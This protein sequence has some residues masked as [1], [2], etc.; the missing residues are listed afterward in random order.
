MF[1]VI[2]RRAKRL[3]FAQSLILK[4]LREVLPESSVTFVDAPNS[5]SLPF[6]S[7]ADERG[8][9]RTIIHAQMSR[10]LQVGK[11]PGVAVTAAGIQV[12]GLKVEGHPKS[13]PERGAGLILREA[14]RYGARILEPLEITLLSFGCHVPATVI[15]Q[16]LV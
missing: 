10:E 15:E 14:E 6:V 1:Y 7:F 5:L 13:I 12:S 11:A 9:E 4:L 8:F 2:Y 16:L 3:H